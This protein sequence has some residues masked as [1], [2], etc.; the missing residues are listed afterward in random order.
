MFLLFQH[1]MLVPISFNPKGI[2]QFQIY[3][4][5]FVT[6]IIFLLSVIH[7]FCVFGGKLGKNKPLGGEKGEGHSS[8]GGF[9]DR[10][11]GII[12][13]ASVYTG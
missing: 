13:I 10:Q 6:F 2:N 1:N 9:Y 12:I 11:Y 8:K 7:A 4:Y 5:K 3:I